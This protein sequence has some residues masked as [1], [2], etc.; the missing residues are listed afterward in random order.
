MNKVH[1]FFIC[2]E[3][4]ARD[5][6]GIIK[7]LAQKIFTDFMCINCQYVKRKEFKSFRSVQI[8]MIELG[9]CMMNPEYLS[10]FKRFYDY[11]GEY[12]RIV[13]KYELKQTQQSP[14]D[15]S[16][17]KPSKTIAED[18][19]WEDVS[20]DENQS[21]AAKQTSKTQVK[22]LLSNHFKRN[23]LGELIL[24]NNKLLGTKKYLKYYNQRFTNYE[25]QRNFYVRAL[26]NH[27]VI[28]TNTDLMVYN[29]LEELKKIYKL[30]VVKEENKMKTLVK[31]QNRQFQKMD[32]F[33]SKKLLTSRVRK[34]RLHNFVLNKHYVDRNMCCS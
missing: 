28:N 34:D 1:S 32:R 6:L 18:D 19:E 21:Q 9:H 30:T 4:Y 14:Q 29:N 11:S 26:E 22:M 16:K 5:K 17:L 10:D 20:E 23:H 15:S 12:Q 7:E 27:K 25:F 8:H 3:E 13:Q 24:P 31:D 33:Y 2:E